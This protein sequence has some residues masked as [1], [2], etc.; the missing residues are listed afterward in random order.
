MSPSDTAPRAH[1]F[2]ECL[3]FFGVFSSA[4]SN[5]KWCVRS[6]A[7]LSP[8]MR[9]SGDTGHAGA[10][11]RALEYTLGDDV[12]VGTDSK[13][14]SSLAGVEDTDYFLDYF[15]RNEFMLQQ[16]IGITG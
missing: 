9:R 2:S 10:K 11:V 16:G 1:T 8:T 5:P 6:Q 4:I 14:L 13:L 12:L 7:P 3:F 15:L